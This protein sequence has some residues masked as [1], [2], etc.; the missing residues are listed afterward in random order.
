MPRTAF[1]TGG[2][3]FV[4]INLLHALCE[5][6]WSLTALHLPSSNL[7]H[8]QDLPLTLVEGSITDK[9]SLERG[10]P[11]GTEV[12]FHLAGDTNQWARHNDRQRKINVDGT[13]HMIEVAAAKG[14]KTFVHTSSIAAWG[15]VSG[16]TDEQTPQLGNRSWVNYEKTK[17]E[18]E[19]EAL[20]GIEK[21]L[22][23]VVIN[24][25][26]IVGPYDTSSWASMFFALRDGKMPGV[27][28]GTNSFVHVQDVVAALILAVDKGQNGH[29]YLLA[30]ENLSQQEYVAEVVKLM[31]MT[32][33]PPKIPAWVL[34]ILARLTTFGASLTGKEP[35]MTPEIIDFMSRPHYAFSNAKAL[36]E[37]GYTMTPWRQGVAESHQWLIKEGLL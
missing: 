12:V 37:L 20:K 5:Q 25:G 26:A 4:G 29:N 21:G 34:R 16:L 23:V 13:R 19:Q 33:V 15:N 28:P 30:G 18:G 24:P 9:A 6:G 10:M 17:W 2:T 14:V 22:K 11:K 8:I 1:V 36:K 35:T 3:G 31:G 7:G 32:R 27:P